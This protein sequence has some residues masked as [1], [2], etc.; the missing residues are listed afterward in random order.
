MFWD[1]KLDE[2]AVKRAATATEMEVAIKKASCTYMHIF[3]R[4]QVRDNQKDMNGKYC[5]MVWCMVATQLREK[6][7]YCSETNTLKIGLKM[8]IYVAWI[9]PFFLSDF[10]I[11]CI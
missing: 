6:W 8:E 10:S 1:L 3:N 9:F 5:S 2:G 4:I 7:E 11:F